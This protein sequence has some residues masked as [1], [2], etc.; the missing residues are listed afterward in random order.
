[1]EKKL[2]LNGGKAA[3]LNSDTKIGQTQILGSQTRQI[4]FSVVNITKSE[5][6]EVLNSSLAES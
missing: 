3:L 6:E 5:V 4:Q 1:M 2:V